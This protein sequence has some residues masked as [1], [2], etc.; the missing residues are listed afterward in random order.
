M[1]DNSF[2]CFAAYFDH[3]KT[4]ASAAVFWLTVNHLPKRLL[5]RP[6]P[7][8]SGDAVRPGSA[9]IGYRR[10]ICSAEKECSGRMAK[11]P[12]AAAGIAA[13]MTRSRLLR[14][15][16]NET[17]Q[18][19]M[20]ITAKQRNGRLSYLDII[21]FHSE[22]SWIRGQAAARQAA[23]QSLCRERR[24]GNAHRVHSSGSRSDLRG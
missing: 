20:R 14:F 3:P 7:P 19:R 4:A 9:L 21:A 11:V 18:R 12:S 13:G 22:E 5:P 15:A 1:R 23:N 8:D 6:V 2:Y 24:S 10:N 16:G 17:E